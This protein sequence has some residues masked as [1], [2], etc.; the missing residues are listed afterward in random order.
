[1]NSEQQQALIDW[2]EKL[3]AALHI[4]GLRWR[5]ELV[6]GAVTERVLA[7][8]REVREMPEVW[9]LRWAMKRLQLE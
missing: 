2:E 5:P 6:C 7:L 8:E 4:H 1:M 3:V 9:S